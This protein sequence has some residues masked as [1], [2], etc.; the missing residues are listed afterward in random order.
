MIRKTLRL[1]KGDAVLTVPVR[2]DPE[3]NIGAFNARVTDVIRS[4]RYL[5]ESPTPTACDLYGAAVEALY[6]LIF[7]KNWTNV[8]LSWYGEDVRGMVNAVNPFISK[9]IAPAVSAAS[10]ARRIRDKRAFLKEQKRAIRT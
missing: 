3:A 7:G 5:K 2:F 10:K 4:E 6:L 8:I 1:K 9:D